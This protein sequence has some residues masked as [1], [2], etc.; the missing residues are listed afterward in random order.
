MLARRLGGATGAA[1]VLAR[2]FGLAV[3]VAVMLARRLGGATGAA[4]VLARFLGLAVVVAVMLA[5]L[6]GGATGAAF[7]LARFL[8]LAVVVAFVPVLLDRLAERLATR[9]RAGVY[10]PQKAHNGQGRHYR[11][12]YSCSSRLHWSGPFSSS[13]VSGFERTGAAASATDERPC[14]ISPSILATARW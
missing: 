1:F 9:K 8:G 3:V 14:A 12:P 4:F 6:L 7:V 2:L 11:H 10:G 5:R 13:G